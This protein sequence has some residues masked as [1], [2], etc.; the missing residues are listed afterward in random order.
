MRGKINP[1]YEELLGSYT[2]AQRRVQ[3]LERDEMADYQQ[4]IRARNDARVAQS[5]LERAERSNVIPPRHTIR[6]GP[7][8]DWGSG[9]DTVTETWGG[10]ERFQQEMERRKESA[11][12]NSLLSTDKSYQRLWDQTRG[13]LR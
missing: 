3:E 7:S 1:R 13:R 4:V 8:T 9:Q 10:A 12:E 2:S 5:R 11:V 6:N